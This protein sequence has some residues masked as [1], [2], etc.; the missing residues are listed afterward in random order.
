MVRSACHG[1]VEYSL[2]LFSSL[3]HARSGRRPA[4]LLMRGH[5]VPSLG[6]WC[7]EMPSDSVLM[8]AWFISNHAR[9]VL[10]LAW[11]ISNHTHSVLMLAWFISYHARSVLEHAQAPGSA[12]AYVPYAKRW[13]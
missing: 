9:F 6:Q 2:F 7:W 8:L 5:G 11:F 10:I 3:A 12:G 1:T 13:A 4:A